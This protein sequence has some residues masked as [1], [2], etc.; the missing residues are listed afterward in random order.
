MRKPFS[1]VVSKLQC[2][3]SEVPRDEK[4]CLN[5]SMVS[6][7][8]FWS[9]EVDAVIRCCETFLSEDGV[10]YWSFVSVCHPH[11]SDIVRCRYVSASRFVVI[12]RLR[13]AVLSRHHRIY[14]VIS[15][16]F[17]VFLITYSGVYIGRLSV[18]T[19]MHG[20]I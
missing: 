18:S 10:K 17:F 6:I 7:T 2:S 5:S 11:F 14:Y 19:C 8:D 1:C 15:G 3:V 20:T 9:L 4:Y 12:A 16:I 13:S